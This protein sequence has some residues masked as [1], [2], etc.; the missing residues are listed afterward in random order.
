MRR[1]RRST[2]ALVAFVVAVATAIPALPALASH[3]STTILV[4]QA[5]DGSTRNNFDDSDITVLA[6]TPI[7]FD[8]VDGNNHDLQWAAD[9]SSSLPSAPIQTAG[10]LNVT[11]T[12]AGTYIYYCSLHTNAATALAASD[13]AAA[14]P[15]EMYGR[16]VVTADTT[17]P[18][19]TPSATATAAGASQIDLTWG[20]ATDDSGTVFYD[21][22]QNT[23]DDQPSATLIRD[24][25]AGN[26]Y[27]A[28][29]LSSGTTY[30]YWIV[31][32]DGAGNVGTAATASATTSSVAASQQAQ[33]ALTFDVNPSL[34]ISVDN[35]A[36]DF[37]TLSAAAP[38]P[39][40]SA[41]VTI[42]SND[43]W[44]LRIRTS[45]PD[46]VDASSRT[47]PVSRATWAA[48]GDA[49]VAATPLSPADADVATAQPAGSASI[50][51]DYQIALLP[52][53]LVGTNYTTTVLYTVTQP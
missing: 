30:F 17:A 8:W 21:V 36:L 35:S 25:E 19:W 12:V 14:R 38:S 22:Y 51:F 32:V 15:A 31:P 13:F 23:V 42:G 48:S 26:A 45:G 50:T 18:V 39:V 24:N 6:G 37:G 49:T 53:D 43:T 28:F 40:Q 3:G 29:G 33:T 27:S 9:P 52:S 4:G 47:I 20:T 11:P 5:N 34:T 7:T 46:F 41:N 10:T 2:R 1:G 44:S 16:I